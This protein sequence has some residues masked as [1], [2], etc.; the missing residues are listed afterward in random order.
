MSLKFIPSLARNNCIGIGMEDFLKILCIVRKVEAPFVINILQP[1]EIL[2][3]K[4]AVSFTVIREKDALIRDVMAHDLVLFFRNWSPSTL[5]LLHFARLSG[6]PVVYAVD[7]N[8]FELSSS[9]IGP[10]KEAELNAY[11]GYI[12]N[13]DLVMVY[14]NLMVERVR[15]LN[16]KVIKTAPGGIDFSVFEGLNRPPR[17]ETIKI[18]YATSRY[19][20]DILSGLFLPALKKIL[21][22]Y[23]GLVEIDL[24]GYM[25]EGLED[26]PGVNHVEKMEYGRYMKRLYSGGFDIGLAPLK[27]DLFHRSKTNTKFRDYGACGIAGI[28]SDVDVYSDVEDGKTG[29]LVENNDSAWYGAMKRLIE[30][31]NLRDSI[32]SNAYGYVRKNYDMNA[33]ADNLYETLLKTTDKKGAKEARIP[34]KNGIAAQFLDLRPPRILFI[35]PP[36]GNM[37][38][39]MPRLMK[40][41]G[42]PFKFVEAKSPADLELTPKLKRSISLSDA[43]VCLDM[44]CNVF[45]SETPEGKVFSCKD[46]DIITVI[47]EIE[48]T[49]YSGIHYS[50]S[51]KALWTRFN[52]F[53]NLLSEVLFKK[54]KI[55]SLEQFFRK[56]VRNPVRDFLTKK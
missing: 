31:V 45:G 42:Y 2:K 4:S 54:T 28:Y 16:E 24:W 43:V 32:K 55:N 41:Y 14:S 36:R 35:S 38:K 40:S 29:L 52:L 13:S 51:S 21:L 15:P 47:N 30:D 18:I 5:K 56:S 8:F 10:M 7:D 34:A 25:P 3:A 46:A 27:D 19:K 44:D 37:I 17:Q 48:R 33:A 39:D 6:K 20:N 22:E 12:T 11:S 53:R 23:R 9:E 26:I 1:L 50:F 49:Y